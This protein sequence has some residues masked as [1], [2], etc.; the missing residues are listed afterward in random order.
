M[1]FWE[2]ILIAVVGTIVL[3]PDKL[4]GAL[5]QIV[6]L[7]RKLSQMAQGVSAEVSEQLRI[8][9]LHQNLKEAEKQGFENLAP[10]LQKSVDEL[11]KAA[12]S[13]NQP[14]SQVA[15]SLQDTLS[16][17]APTHANAPSKDDSNLVPKTPPAE[18]KND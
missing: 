4:P 2:F 16:H 7:K 15:T 1:G 3:G 5:R 13:V 6:Q 10:D 12:E 8:H 17:V 11:K 14:A 9:E 18:Q